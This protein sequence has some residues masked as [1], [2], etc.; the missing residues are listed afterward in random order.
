SR[1]KER[2]WASRHRSRM[3][4]RKSSPRRKGCEP[5]GGSAAK[6]WTDE[7]PEADMES[8]E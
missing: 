3:K 1:C 4:W 5:A 2:P 6:R 8:K 7:F